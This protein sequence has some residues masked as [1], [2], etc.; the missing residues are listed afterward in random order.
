M[1]TYYKHT[2]KESI[3]VPYSFCCEQC[4]KESGTLQATIVG[5]QAEV[6]SN[7]K[8]L[9]EK[10]QM[11]LDNMAHKKLVRSVKDAYQ[12]A[13][14]KQIFI[15]TFNDECPHCHMPQSWAVS[16]AKKDMYSWPFALAVVGIVLGIG[17]YFYDDSENGP[18]IALGAFGVFLVLAAGVLIFNMIKVGNK[19]R[20]TSDSLQKNLPKIDWS[21][22]Q[23][24]LDE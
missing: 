21:A 18:L 13:T 11:Q 12:N 1:S 17:Y 15:K 4:M 8:N 24:L 14:E 10:K 23:H 5:N 22:V 6:D 2:K 9:N 3:D 19:K 16:G 20:Q 7:F